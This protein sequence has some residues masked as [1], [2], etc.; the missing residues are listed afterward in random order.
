MSATIKYT[1]TVKFG[2]FAIVLGKD[3]LMYFTDGE[4]SKV[5]DVAPSFNTKDLYD[6]AVRISEKNGFGPVE[7]TTK[8]MVV[9]KF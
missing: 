1:N 9:K 5:R 3:Q 6:L 4:L 7:C 8:E 2:K